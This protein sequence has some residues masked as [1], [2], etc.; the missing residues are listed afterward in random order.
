V[1]SFIGE[2]AALKRLALMPVSEALI[3]NKVESSTKLDANQNLRVAL[4]S[5]LLSGG[6]TL[7][8]TQNGQLVGSVSIES[9]SSARGVDVSKLSG[10]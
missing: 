3:S 6:K 2:G 1:A 5:I 7:G 4:D 8:V 10:N 9:I